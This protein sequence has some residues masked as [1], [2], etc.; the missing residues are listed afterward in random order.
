MPYKTKQENT[1]AP[2]SKGC[3]STLYKVVDSMEQTAYLTDIR[4]KH[5]CQHLGA[6][7]PISK[8]LKRTSV[9]RV[10]LYVVFFPD[11]LTC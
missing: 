7:L 11:S 9:V 3:P 8:T 6:N 5:K 2:I 1:D 4:R 10:T